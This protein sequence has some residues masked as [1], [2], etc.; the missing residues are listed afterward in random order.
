MGLDVV[1]MQRVTPPAT[2]TADSTPPDANPPTG[3][4]RVTEPAV[5][6]AVTRSAI[7]FPLFPLTALLLMDPNWRHPG[8]VLART[9]VIERAQDPEEPEE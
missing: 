2:D 7:R 3:S 8:D 4:V 6:Q 5:W 9:V 1:A